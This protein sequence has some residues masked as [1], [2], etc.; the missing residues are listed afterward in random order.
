MIKKQ[1]SKILILC[2]LMLFLLPIFLSGEEDNKFLLFGIRLIP[3]PGNLSDSWVITQGGDYNIV[4]NLTVG[5][6]TGMAYR[7]FEDVAEYHFKTFFNSKYYVA[8]L[9]NTTFYLGAGAG[10]VELLKVTKLESNFSLFIG[11]QGIIGAKI[12]PPKK[13]KFSIEIQFFKS[14]EKGRELQIL[15]LAGVRF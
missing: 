13:D 1:T 6:E 12:G 9:G 7:I 11:Y 8:S 5:F 15:L 10:L 4:G 14:T 2:C 3:S